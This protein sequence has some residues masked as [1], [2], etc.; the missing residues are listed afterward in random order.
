MRT[1]AQ[2][3]NWRFE[4]K[5]SGTLQLFNYWNPSPVNFLYIYVHLCLCINEHIT[6]TYIC[7]YKTHPYKC[8][9]CAVFYALSS[10][11]EMALPSLRPQSLHCRHCRENVRSG[12][13][14][15][16]GHGCGRGGWPFGVG[17]WGRAAGMAAPGNQGRQ[18]LVISATHGVKSATHSLGTANAGV[19]EHHVHCLRKCVHVRVYLQKIWTARSRPWNQNWQKCLGRGRS[20]CEVAGTGLLFNFKSRQ[21]QGKGPVYM[22]ALVWQK[23]AMKYTV[24]LETRMP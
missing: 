7:T 6:Q 23:L 3:G 1:K 12:F 18:N 24:Q 14:G 11:G 20:L 19:Q 15:R 16:G 21:G 17:G 10:Q 13:S 8:N 22:K 5:K 2:N 4:G 9:V